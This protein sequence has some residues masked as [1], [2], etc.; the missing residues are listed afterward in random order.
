MTRR[1]KERRADA[2][3][4]LDRFAGVPAQVAELY[5]ERSRAIRQA[6]E[7]GAGVSEIADRL[8][9]PR[10]VVYRAINPNGRDD[11]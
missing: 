7:A 6:F 10:S 3:G 1:Q 4:S 9:V 8:G 2:L 5:G 11:Q